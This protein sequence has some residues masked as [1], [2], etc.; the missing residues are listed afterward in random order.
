MSKTFGDILRTERKKKELSQFELGKHLN[1]SKQTISGYENNSS[2]PSHE[3]LLKLSK[4]FNVSTDYLLGITNDPSPTPTV[5]YTIAEIKKK[6]KAEGIDMEDLNDED[7]IEMLAKI[8]K[9]K[10]K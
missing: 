5:D 1:L 4:L 10:K 8:V 2:F 6:L 9:M 7:I 3:S